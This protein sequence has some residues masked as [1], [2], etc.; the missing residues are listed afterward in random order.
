MCGGQIT[1]VFKP[2]IHTIMHKEK[3]VNAFIMLLTGW[4]IW[5]RDQM[6]ET[7]LNLFPRDEGQNIKD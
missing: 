4:F 1:I 5:K 7:V 6:H 3:E 2:L